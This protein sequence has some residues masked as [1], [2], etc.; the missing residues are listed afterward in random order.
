MFHC[1]LSLLNLH[2]LSITQRKIIPKEVKAERDSGFS[3][4]NSLDQILDIFFKDSLGTVAYVSLVD[5]QIPVDDKSCGYTGNTAV[6]VRN[7]PITVKNW[8]TD[9]QP[10][11]E[12]RHDRR[13]VIIKR[14]TKNNQIPVIFFL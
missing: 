11:S 7:L 4:V 6:A 13:T 10:F 8:I 5:I 14:D 9:S 12:L 1:L 3:S 2:E